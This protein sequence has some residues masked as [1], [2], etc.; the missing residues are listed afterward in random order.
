MTIKN[1]LTTDI[2]FEV[3]IAKPIKFVSQIAIRPG[4]TETID[5][6]RVL[7]MIFFS[8]EF[9]TALNINDITLG[10]SAGDATYLANIASF[11]AGTLT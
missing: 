5:V 9:Q 10:Y 7:P 2:V 6:Q 8:S 3:E 1:N 4:E 11:L